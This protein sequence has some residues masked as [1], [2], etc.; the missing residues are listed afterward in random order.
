M[1][2]KMP[3]AARNE[4]FCV[5]PAP[6]PLEQ[7]RARLQAADAAAIIK[8]GRQHYELVIQ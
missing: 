6:L 1:G 3:L 8:L 7:L 5:L 4:I 2:A